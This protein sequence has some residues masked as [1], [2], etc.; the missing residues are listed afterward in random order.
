M[1]SKKEQ[2]IA[3]KINNIEFCI[4]GKITIERSFTIKKK[5]KI[6]KALIDMFDI[7]FSINSHKVFFL[8]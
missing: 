8:T 2:T 3:E 5:K 1:N 6:A 4:S 7:N